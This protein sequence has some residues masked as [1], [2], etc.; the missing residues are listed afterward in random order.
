V[1]VGTT[2]GLLL[3]NVPVVFLGDALARKLPMA[4]VHGVAALL[5]AVLGVL[6]LLNVGA[7]FG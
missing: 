1:V 7:V 4:L 2:A 5:F 6:A 3:A